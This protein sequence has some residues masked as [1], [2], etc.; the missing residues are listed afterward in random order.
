MG[1]LS[2]PISL[3]SGPPVGNGSGKLLRL[4]SFNGASFRVTGDTNE[5]VLASVAIPDGF[6]TDIRNELR[7]QYGV[8]CTNNANTKQIRCYVGQSFATAT[9]I[10]VYNVTASNA[11]AGR[12]V[13]IAA[14]PLND[15]RLVVM[16]G[17]ALQHFGGTT[18]GATSP[19]AGRITTIDPTSTG[20]SLY[21]TG[22]LGVDT[23]QLTLEALMVDAV[24]GRE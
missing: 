15:A 9:Q 22:K 2:F 14:D 7:V 13:S 16:L 6:F 3:L 12:Q 5:Y 4:K 17:N 10:N 1:K 21:V 19:L 18:A 23:D 20:L 11:G 8:N 24:Y